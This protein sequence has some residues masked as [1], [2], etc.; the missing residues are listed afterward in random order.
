M[1]G[2]VLVLPATAFTA[3]ALTGTDIDVP[4]ERPP[5]VIQDARSSTEQRPGRGSSGGDERGPSAG[6]SPS[7]RRAAGPDPSEPEDDVEVV[8]PRPDHIETVEDDAGR[9]D[10]PDDDAE[11][12]P[13]EDAGDD[14]DDD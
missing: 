3:G 6:A 4:A 9:D 12:E 11:D 10:E 1:L 7:D 8:N 13:E 2:L 14:R 5:I